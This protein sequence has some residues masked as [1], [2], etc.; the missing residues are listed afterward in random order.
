MKGARI[1]MGGG[2]WVQSIYRVNIKVIGSL[3]Y[4]LNPK[5]LGNMQV[6][7]CILL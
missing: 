4:R 1:P 6:N 3:F 5:T 7:Y 2:D